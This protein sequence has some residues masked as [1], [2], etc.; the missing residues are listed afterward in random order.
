MLAE[1]GIPF[2]GA[3]LL[4]RE[5]ARRLSA[6]ARSGGAGRA[7]AGES[8]STTA[9]CRIRRTG[10]ASESRR[11]RT[12]CC[13][14]SGWRRRSA[15]PGADFRAELERRFGDGGEQRRGVN[16]LTYHA[17]KGLE[18]ELVLLPRLEEKE[19]PCRQA[20]TPAELAE[21]RRLL[22]VGMTRAKRELAITWVGKPSRFLLELG[23]GPDGR[24]SPRRRP[25]RP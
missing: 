10:S 5:A 12:T 21:E 18:F 13:G 11:G 15:G 16:L 25:S 19:L 2:Q 4:E 7:G 17:A 22:Y 14:S 6:R 8:R 1:A 9:G 24:A 20:R 3:S 23:S